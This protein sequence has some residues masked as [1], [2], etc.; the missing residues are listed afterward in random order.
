MSHTAWIQQAESD[1]A[2]AKILCGASHHSQ[3]IWLAGQAVEKAHK[4]I[5]AALG[6]RYEERHYKQ[7]GHRTAEIS[8]LLP[9]ALHEP[10]DPQVGTMLVKLETRALASR[11]LAPAPTTGTGATQVIAP[12]SSVTTSQQDIA[13]AERLITW[14]R[15]RIQRAVRA[16]QAM[17]P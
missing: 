4:A 9:R 14:C 7:L 2:A 1:L 17:K 11:Y 12:A 6:L 3:A 10:V 16:E 5:L 13:D 15:D 8:E